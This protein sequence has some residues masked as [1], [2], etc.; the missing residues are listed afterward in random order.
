MKKKAVADK[1]KTWDFPG[2]PENPM[3]LSRKTRATL[4]KAPVSYVGKNVLLS[5]RRVQARN[6]DSSS[7]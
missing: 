6:R 5:E 4:G 1:G 2:N 7:L 3:P